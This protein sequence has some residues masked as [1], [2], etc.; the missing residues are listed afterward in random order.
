MYL[1]WN[2]D[3]NFTHLYMLSSGQWRIV[4]RKWC[5]IVLIVFRGRSASHLFLGFWIL[6]FW[7]IIPFLYWRTKVNM[8]LFFFYYL[9]NSFFLFF[10]TENLQK[11]LKEA[12]FLLNIFFLFQ[13]WTYWY[14]ELI[15]FQTQKIFIFL[16]L[17]FFFFFFFSSFLN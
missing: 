10:K 4:W 17:I 2:P 11:L 16:L 1:I 5:L 9:I 13:F 14:K 3:I 12:F 7:P 15:F 6:R 8:W